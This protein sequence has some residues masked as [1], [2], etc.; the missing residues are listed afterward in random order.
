[1][2]V[3]EILKMNPDSKCKIIYEGSEEWKH[4]Y[5]QFKN[6]NHKDLD[7]NSLP[8][9]D[10]E[11]LGDTGEPLYND[12]GNEVFD[13]TQ[14]IEYELYYPIDFEIS[15]ESKT[16]ISLLQNKIK[17]WIES[18]EFDPEDE[19]ADFSEFLQEDI[20]VYNGRGY[21]DNLC[22]VI[23]CSDLENLNEKEDETLLWFTSSQL[24]EEN[25]E[26]SIQ[27]IKS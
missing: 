20:G 9:L 23:G 19:Y 5:H 10:D 6:D 16:F 11:Y 18:G 13:P 26:V 15:A 2:D 14:E 7:V 27:E 22:D 24:D 8:L 17:E 3:N 1:M 12:D 4:C 21:I 25:G